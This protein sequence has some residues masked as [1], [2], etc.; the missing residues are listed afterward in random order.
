M[1]GYYAVMFITIKSYIFFSI[2][3]T[4]PFNFSFYLKKA[5]VKQYDKVYPLT[6][7]KLGEFNN[8]CGVAFRVRLAL[9]PGENGLPTK[10]NLGWKRVCEALLQRF[11]NLLLKHVESKIKCMEW[12]FDFYSQFVADADS[13][14]YLKHYQILPQNKP[15]YLKQLCKPAGA[16]DQF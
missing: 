8:I 5:T 10:H 1:L 7:E 15:L 13:P 4:L 3:H 11:E 14:F 16:I 12:L 9:V 6:L 2:N